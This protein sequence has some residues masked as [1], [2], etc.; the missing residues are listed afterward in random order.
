MSSIL[1]QSEFLFFDDRDED[2][3]ENGPLP[4]TEPLK[5]DSPFSVFK[6]R[7]LLRQMI[8]SRSVRTIYQPIVDMYSR[9]ILG[10]EALGRGQC[11]KL[12]DRPNELF[13][14][15]HICALAADLSRAFRQ[16]AFAESRKLPPG[17]YIFCNLH[18][19]ELTPQLPKNL[20]RL[21]PELAR[22][23]QIS[24][25]SSRGRD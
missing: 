19:D 10:Y 21:L 2:N 16:A 24:F 13:R 3:S 23:P 17:P 8:E 5:K 15:A 1:A 18:P 12:T 7:P 9:A 22:R 14:I 6:S 20:D 4:K 11:E 25:G